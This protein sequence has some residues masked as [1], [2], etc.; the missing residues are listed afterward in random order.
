MLSPQQVFC[1]K[2]LPKC[3][4]IP[5][6]WGSAP[7]PLGISWGRIR[8][9]CYPCTLEQRRQVAKSLIGHRIPAATAGLA[10]QTPPHAA[11]RQHPQIISPVAHGD[12]IGL[13]QN[14]A[15]RVD[16]SAHRLWL[17]SKRIGTPHIRRSTPRLRPAMYSL[18]FSSN[19][20]AFA[21]GNG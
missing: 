20:S 5:G 4:K 1:L 6:V 18:R 21:T 17:V 19:P 15:A 9:W 14:P 10:L 16:S 11:R 2:P 7:A 8:P 3:G 13:G 12:H